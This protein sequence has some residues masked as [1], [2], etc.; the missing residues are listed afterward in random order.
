MAENTK[1]EWCDHS[2]SPWYGCTKVAIGCLHCFA[3]T[4]S[5]RNPGTLGVWGDNGTRVKSKS[6]VANIRKW[7]R[8]AKKNGE[9]VTVFPSLCDPFEDRPELEPW[10]AEMFRV[11]DEC[12]NVRLLLLTK[13]PENIRRMWPQI[14]NSEWCPRCGRSRAKPVG[15]GYESCDCVLYR[16]NVALITSISTQEDA[17]RNIPL[18]LECRDLV[19]ILGVSAEPLLRPVDL[20]PKAPETYSVL[21]RYYST[22]TFDPSGMSPAADRVL[23]CFPRVDWVIAGGESGPNSRPCWVTWIRDLVRQCADTDTPCFVKQLGANAE[24]YHS[25]H[26][27][28][29]LT[30]PK[31]GD[32]DEWPEDVRVR[33]FPK[34]E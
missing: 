27:K 25:T 13:R 23:N 20:R 10:R 19:P 14:I 4:L 16:R 34:W 8:L 22:G 9:F 24:G 11:I 28:L 21:G 18:L 29:N 6:F 2:A 32:I 1:I 31:G 17:D 5:R 7:D 33:Q 26:R 12:Q 3:E 30:D 15:D